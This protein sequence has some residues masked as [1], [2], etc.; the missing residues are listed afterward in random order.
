MTSDMMANASNSTV[1]QIAAV[2]QPVTL[3]DREPPVGRRGLHADA[4]KTQRRDREDGVAE[5]HRELDEDR[6][7]MLGRISTHMTCSAVSPRNRAAAT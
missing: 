2:D 6:P 5:A 1:H 7:R 4:E 3:R